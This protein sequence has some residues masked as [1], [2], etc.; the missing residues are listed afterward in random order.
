MQNIESIEDEKLLSGYVPADIY[1]E[2]KKAASVRHE[3]LKDA[4]KHAALM[5]IYAEQDK[6]VK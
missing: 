3:K 6:E 5:Y 2:F 4:L 1:W